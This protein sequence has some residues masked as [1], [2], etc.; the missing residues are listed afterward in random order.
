MCPGGSR[1]PSRLGA[2]AALNAAALCL[3]TPPLRAQLRS[4]VGA[5]ASAGLRVRSDTP[6]PLAAT[7]GADVH[8]HVALVPLVRVGGSAGL[9]ESLPNGAEEREYY[10]MGLEARVAS[11]WT[12]APWH[13]WAFM[14]VGA[15]YVVATRHAAA[16]AVSPTGPGG[17]QSSQLDGALFEVPIGVGAGL[18]LHST[19]EIDAVLSFRPVIANL[20]PV[21]RPSAVP[22]TQPFAGHEVLAVSLAV[23]VSFCR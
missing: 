22:D 4:D 19:W 1:C 9:E 2:A 12:R 14:G 20:G 8:G 10:T 21:S 11:P 5:Q 17:P 23:G 3:V 18:R 16:T 7:V 13:A 15:A 6:E